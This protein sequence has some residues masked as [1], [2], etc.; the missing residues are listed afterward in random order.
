MDDRY[1]HQS[2]AVQC[3]RWWRYT[4]FYTAWGLWA[5]TRWL[6]FSRE[7]QMCETE[8]HKWPMYASL[9]DAYWGIVRL[10]K[11]LA[12]GKMKYY[13]TLQEVLADLKK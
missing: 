12:Q 2:Y 11:S 13:Y 10:Y 6:I 1:Q 5:A 3:Y 4:P 9:W 7:I 8:N